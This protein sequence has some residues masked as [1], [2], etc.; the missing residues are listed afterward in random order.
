VSV[1]LLMLLPPV[2]LASIATGL[3]FGLTRRLHW[4]AVGSWLSALVV[5][6]L[7]VIIY[8][9]MDPGRVLAWFI[10]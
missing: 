7:L 6:W 5:S 9:R 2:G 3:W 8:G 4:K 1:A 10:D